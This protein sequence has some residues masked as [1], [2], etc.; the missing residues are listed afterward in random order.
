MVYLRQA[1]S[2]DVTDIMQI[3]SEAKIF[4]GKS[5]SDQWQGEYPAIE[6][7]EEDLANQVAYVLE[8]DGKVAGYS[9]V[10]TGEE[11]NYTK[12]TDGKWSNDSLDY[13]T[14][15]RIALSDEFRGQSLTK[16]LFSN[17]YS[18]MNEKGY[19]DFRVDTHEM[20]QIMQ[21]VFE[22]EGFIYRGQVIIDGLR[23][24]YQ[25]EL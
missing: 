10:I 9:A 21:H 12:I 16:F 18:L 4:L 2:S 17:I 3:I 23:R 25:K 6:N 7:I 15:H 20:N 1:T 8:I 24:A 11:P 22:R 19:R 5:G 14:V 13:V